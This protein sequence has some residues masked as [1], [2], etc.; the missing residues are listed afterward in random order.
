MTK[1]CCS[2]STIYHFIV[3]ASDMSL[4]TCEVNSVQTNEKESIVIAH[5]GVE[6]QRVGSPREGLSASVQVVIGRGLRELSAILLL[7]V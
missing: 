1:K 4:L 3:Y 2:S 6:E 7:D 5:M